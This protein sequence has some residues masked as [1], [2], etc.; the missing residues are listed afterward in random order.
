MKLMNVGAAAIA[1]ALLSTPAV[2]TAQDKPGEMKIPGTNTTLK[3]N[4]FVEMD[5]IY[6]LSGA[7]EDIRGDDWASFL[8]FQPLDQGERFKNRLYMTA[9]T[10]RIGLTL[11]T[12]T[13]GTPIVVRVEGDFNSPTAYNYSTEAT[14]NGVNFRVRHAYGEYAGFLVGQTWSNFTD[15]GSLPDTVDFN[16]H[17]AF[18]LTRQIGVRYTAKMGKNSLSV[19]AE[20]PQSIV[21]NTDLECSSCSFTVGRTFDRMPDLSASYTMQLPFG[22]VNVRG[23]L[24]EYQGATTFGDKSTEDSKLG[25]GAGVSGSVNIAKDALVWSVQ[26]GDGIGKY[27]FQSLFQGAA[28]TAPGKIETWKTVAYHLGYTHNWTPSMRSNLIWSQTFFDKNDAL[29]VAEVQTGFG[30]VAANKRVDTATVNT[31]VSP[32]KGVD[33]GL[34]YFWGQR[35]VFHAALDA[36]LDGNGDPAPIPT[37]NDT[38]TQHRVN[39]LVRYSFF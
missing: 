35:T 37:S 36:Q 5:A 21:T 13:K 14:T 10:S 20:N 17:G 23:V 19:A 2:G 28:F 12:P 25:W 1:A 31:F 18:A 3:L 11:T 4:G 24:Q 8:E 27:M 30:N 6:D 22:H 26:G 38:G 29:A 33:I 34:E 16:P 32:V 15:L 39:A 9:R 7:D